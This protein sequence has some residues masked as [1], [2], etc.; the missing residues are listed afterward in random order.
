MAAR[1]DWWFKQGIYCMSYTQLSWGGGQRDGTRYQKF[2]PIPS[3]YHIPTNTR[4]ASTRPL[5]DVLFLLFAFS[6]SLAAGDFSVTC[7]PPVSLNPGLT[8]H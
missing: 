7:P 8:N 1:T 6:V 2:L 3:S 5:R 4:V